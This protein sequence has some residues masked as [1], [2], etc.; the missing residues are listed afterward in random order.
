MRRK[1]NRREYEDEDSKEKYSSAFRFLK[2]CLMIVTWIA[3]GIVC[4]IMGPALEDLKLYLG[5]DY[6]ELSFL[7]SLKQASHLALILIG[8]MLFDKFSFYADTIMC[9]SS[10][11]LVVRK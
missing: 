7:I 6:N 5:V 3:F 9:I 2:T 11:L 1:T 8:G 4:E 10:I